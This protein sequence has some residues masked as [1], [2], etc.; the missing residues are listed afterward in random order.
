VHLRVPGPEGHHLNVFAPAATPHPR[1]LTRGATALGVFALA[2]LLGTAFAVALSSATRPSSTLA[3]AG[4][5]AALAVL[6]LALARYQTAAALGILIF[7]VVFVEPSPP[8]A[9]LAIVMAV[10]IITGRFTLRRVPFPILAL[11]GVF[12]VL[13]LVSAVFATSPSRAGFYLLITT[14]LCAFA[15]WITTF[16]NSPRRARMLVVPLL[17]GA[18]ASA[19]IGV[20]VLYVS[21]PG[22]SMLNFSDGYRARGFFKD[23]NVFGPFCVFAG[24]L[25]VSELLEP[26]LLRARRGLK[27]ILLAVL[28]FGVLFSYS[29]AAWLNAAVAIVIMIVSYA[30]RR[31]GGRKVA[32]MLITIVVLA[33]A[34]SVTLAATGS[35]GFLDSRAHF[36]S[37]DVRRFAAQREGLQIVQSYPFGIGP[38]QFE[39]DIGYASH[40]TYIRVLAEQGFLGLFVMLSLL[41]GTLGLAARNVVLGRDTFGIGSVPLLATFSGVLANS[42]FVDTIHWRHVWL[43]AGLIWAGA[44]RSPG[45]DPRDL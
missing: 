44:M 22:S 34:G 8:D 28:A 19:A 31:G 9:V 39:R 2:A 15:V 11:L 38:G 23:P 29:R 41:L 26:R 20:A 45:E 36:Q 33:G 4:G 40:N 6:A 17:A 13:N 27:L 37:Y 32:A 7:S 16:V 5:I 35:V 30:L 10:A 12:L 24:L 18:V 1:V 21:F 42:A 43:V 25:V 14:Y 3:A